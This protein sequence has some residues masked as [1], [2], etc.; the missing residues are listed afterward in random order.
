[1]KWKWTE[2]EVA[3]RWNITVADK[4]VVDNMDW[5]TAEWDNTNY[6]TQDLHPYVLYRAGL[7]NIQR[8]FPNSNRDLVPW[9]TVEE[10]RIIN[11]RINNGRK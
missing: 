9:N 5:T 10:D 8:M 6:K 2:E 7:D 11:E 4:K 1:M 3:K